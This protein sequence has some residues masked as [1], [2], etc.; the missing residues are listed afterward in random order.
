MLFT[1]SSSIAAFRLAMLV[2]FFNLLKSFGILISTSPTKCSK[3]LRFESNPD[4]MSKTDSSSC[5]LCD[6]IDHTPEG[7]KVANVSWRTKS[8]ECACGYGYKP[9]QS[10]ESCWESSEIGENTEGSIDT[11]L[12]RVLMVRLGGFPF[13]RG[14]PIVNED[15]DM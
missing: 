5:F 9:F 3:F 1:F 12:G 10:K 14:L 2:G 8:F 11:E 15:P 13:A 4:Q 6:S 7:V